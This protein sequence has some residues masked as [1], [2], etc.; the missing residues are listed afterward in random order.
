M[1]EPECHLAWSMKMMML[2][3][4]PGWAA[5]GTRRP[6]HSA[7]DAHGFDQNAA[8][9]AEPHTPRTNPRKKSMRSSRYSQKLAVATLGILAASCSSNNAQRGG[10]GGSRPSSGGASGG[11]TT[12][13]S[14]GQVGSGGAT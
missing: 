9:E 13:S 14:G 3:S 8:V 4:I 6:R 10:S 11:A 2:F 1:G 12:V 5:D 7:T